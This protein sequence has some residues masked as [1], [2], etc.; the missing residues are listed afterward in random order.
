MPC[1][2]RRLLLCDSHPVVVFCP[3]E[4]HVLGVILFLLF[5]AKIAQIKKLQAREFS[6]HFGPTPHCSSETLRDS[7]LLS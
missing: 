1:L 4:R 5:L 7:E 6:L 3:F 2:E